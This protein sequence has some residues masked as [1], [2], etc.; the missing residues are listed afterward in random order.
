MAFMVTGFQRTWSVLTETGS[1]VQP[2]G[3]RRWDA[4]PRDC[5]EF[6]DKAPTRREAIEAFRPSKDTRGL[7]ESC[8]D[9]RPV[10]R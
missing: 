4:R 5:P 8:G 1:H 10:P 6:C 2:A 3:D 7:E 9:F